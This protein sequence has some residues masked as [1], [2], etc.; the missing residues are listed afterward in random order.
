M[1]EKSKREEIKQ[2][3]RGDR[4]IR[5]T[6]KKTRDITGRQDGEFVDG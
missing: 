5:T 6:R 2:E 1:F 4:K 3:T